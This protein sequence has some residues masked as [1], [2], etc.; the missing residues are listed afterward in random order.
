MYL[1]SYMVLL[2]C[3]FS[4]MP[5]ILC[6]LILFASLPMVSA[7]NQE[8]QFP[9]IVFSD[10]I[11]NMFASKISLANVLLIL[12]SLLENPEL[13]NLHAR[14]KYPEVS[15]EKKSVASSWLKTFGKK[16][17]EELGNDPKIFFQQKE[18]LDNR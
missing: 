17:V 3:L 8:N 11:L 6:F 15:G 16:V 12:F 4:D 2:L 14:Q 10:F 18:F 13:L 1:Y 7:H 9:N 5:W